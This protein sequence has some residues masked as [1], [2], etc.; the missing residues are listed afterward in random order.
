MSAESVDDLVVPYWLTASTEAASASFVRML[1]RL[2]RLLLRAGQLAAQ[3]SRADTLA[4]V[5]FGLAGGVASGVGLV[6]VVGVLDGLMRAGP[7]PERLR[8]AAPSVLVMVVA[9]AL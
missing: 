8:A 6:N 2:P 3:T 4:V 7:T 1:R 5:G 9:G